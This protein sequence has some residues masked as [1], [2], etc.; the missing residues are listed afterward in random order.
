MEKTVDVETEA[1]QD[2]ELAWSAL[3]R[4]QQEWQ[5]MKQT[6]NFNQQHTE[7]QAASLGTP[8][9]GHVWSHREEV[10]Q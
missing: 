5:R 7:I 3:I 4:Q 2:L 8:Q 9:N 6:F 1:G 10:K